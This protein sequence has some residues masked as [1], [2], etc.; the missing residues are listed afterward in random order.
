MVIRIPGPSKVENSS[1]EKMAGS[2]NDLRQN[3]HTGISKQRA[4][5]DKITEIDEGAFYGFTALEEI[6]F[7]GVKK[8]GNYAFGGC[9]SLQ[10]LN[11]DE[12][13]K[14]IGEGAFPGCKNLKELSVHKNNKYFST[15]DNML[16]N[17]SQ[18]KIVSA[19]FGSNKTCHIYSSIKDIDKN[20]LNEPET[21]PKEEII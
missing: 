20:I 11:L 6:Q 2:F 5:N 3:S 15:R 17:K 18:S 16:L 12:N 19:C 13:L 21:S 4:V 9:I 8:I 7:G 10:T 14:E 1:M